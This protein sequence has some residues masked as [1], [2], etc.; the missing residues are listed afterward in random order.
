V[1]EPGSTGNNTPGGINQPGSTGNNTPGGINQTFYLPNDANHVTNLQIR[2]D[3]YCGSTVTP[4]QVH[5]VY[6]SG[7]T[8][9]PPA[10]LPPTTPGSFSGTVV[11]TNEILWSWMDSTNEAGYWVR[12]SGGG[13]VSSFLLSNTTVYTETGLTPNTRYRRFILAS[14]QYGTASSSTQ[15][16][17]TLP[18]PPQGLTVSLTGQTKVGLSWAAGSGGA[19]GY[20]IDGSVDGSSFG[21]IESIYLNTEYT[22]TGLSAGTK[23]YYRVF[24]LNTNT[25]ASLVSSTTLTVTTLPPTVVTNNRIESLSGS[26]I[27]LG[28]FSSGGVSN[29]PLLTT[30]N[31]KVRVSWGEYTAGTVGFYQ[32]FRALGE[33]GPYELVGVVGP[34]ETSYLDTTTPAH[35]KLYYVV[36]AASTKG[37]FLA[38]T[39]AG[40]I[41]VVTLEKEDEPKIH[42]NIIREGDKEAR[43]TL[44]AGTSGQCVIKVYTVIGTEVVTLFDQHVE[45]GEEIEVVWNFRNESGK[46]VANGLYFIRVSLPKT[47]KSIP[48]AV[49]R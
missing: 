11:S 40:K 20:R 2:F 26:G 45:T 47:R 43:V 21:V 7:L 8:N 31:G 34:G 39:E 41:S 13:N 36:I 37:D 29:P 33:D 42:D 49:R 28:D 9:T 22:N 35:K 25:N 32:I 17:F 24:S 12:D 6:V 14:N 16:I 3:A 1:A 46:E 5:R 18:N 10:P 4:Y 19:Y 15:E 44:R 48:V 27:P 23:Y 38:R 30:S